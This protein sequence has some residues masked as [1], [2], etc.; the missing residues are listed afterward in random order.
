LTQQLVIIQDDALQEKMQAPILKQLPIYVPSFLAFG[1][2]LGIALM[3]DGRVYDDFPGSCQRCGGR[4]CIKVGFMEASF[5]KM[6]ASDKFVDIKVLLQKYICKDC[7][8]PYT[9]NGPFYPG[10]MYGSPIVDLALML[11]ME[12]SSYGV[13][14][15]MMNLG[16]QL[17]ED[18]A[19]DYV[20]LFADRCRDYAPLVK[21]KDNSALYGVNILKILFGVDNV[22]E[23]AEKFPKLDAE[24]LAD[25]AYLRKKGALKKFVEELIEAQQRRVVHRGLKEKDIVLKDGKPSFPESFTLALSYLPGAEA[26]ASLINTPQPFNQLLAELLFKALEGS[27]LKV[28][29]GSHNYNGLRDLECTVHKARNELKKDP[30]VMVMKKEFREIQKRIQEAK[31]EDER[32]TA[33][34]GRKRKRK[35]FREYAKAKY[36]DVLR[37]SLERLK[38]EKPE[39]FDKG[40][41]FRFEHTSTNGME[42]G[43]WRLKYLIR[44][45]HKRNDSSA[46]RSL[47]AAIRD[48][49]FTMRVG[50]VKESLANKLGFFSLGKVMAVARP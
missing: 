25:E 35:E 45:A 21:K 17:S 19:L 11:S 28:T 47:L 24:S 36:Q 14:R 6:I 8:K 33:I 34:E 49:V 26:Y 2:Q 50:K 40:G 43:N 44:Q 23:L 32:R 39:L 37:S 38:K 12:N 1:V 41:N 46:G 27:P 7:G 9:S 29:D 20:R 3:Y 31:S 13:E 16:I 4:N 10:T 5:A 48:S 22:K 30:K 18:T 42:G 15:G